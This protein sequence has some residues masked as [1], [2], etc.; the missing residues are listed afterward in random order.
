MR[1]EWD[2]SKARANAAK[3]KVTFKEAATVWA[4]PF[5][6]IAPDPDHS[7]DELR[8]WIIGTSYLQRLLVVVYTM[9]DENIRIISARIATRNE[10]SRY[11]EESY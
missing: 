9:R 5:A 6:L 4:D 11:E 10:R 3:H 1:F 8:E 7:T 2:D